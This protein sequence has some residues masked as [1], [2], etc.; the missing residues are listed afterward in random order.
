MNDA[1][2]RC[3]GVTKRFGDVQ[4]LRGVD[5]DVERGHTMALLGPSGCGK[6]TL[7]RLI[8]GFELPGG[9]AIMLGGRTLNAPGV[10]VAPEKRRVGMVFQDF[11]LFPHLSVASNIAFGMKRRSGR[12][13][14][15]EELLEMVGLAGLGDRMPHE[16]SGGQQQRV[17]LARSLAAEPD[18]ILLDEPFS[19][20]DPGMRQRLRAEVRQLLESLGMTAMFV[21]HDQEEALSVA[22]RVAVMLDGRVLQVGRPAEV[23]SAPANRDVAEFL[24]DANFIA[25][26]L[27]DGRVACE[28]GSIDVPQ[29]GSGA[30]EVMVRPESLL[31]SGEGGRPV[32]VVAQEY[33]GHD[34]MVTVRLPGGGLLKVREM[35]G[36]DFARGQRLGLQLRG[37]VTVYPVV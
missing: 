27:Q 22:E 10:F 14:R 7:L 12:R 3:T 15:I 31:L 11:A 21:T 32:E 24:G 16:L 37:D 23:Y 17:A 2:L 9:G 33:F 8:A 30:V 36:R 29:A 6:T 1:F 20:L 5:L 4:A 19:N 28:L 26:E 35:P 13:G 25:G 34:Q 18:L